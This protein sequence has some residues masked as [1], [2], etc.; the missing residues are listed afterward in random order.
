MQG[1]ARHPHLRPE[2]GA[3]AASIRRETPVGT[4]EGQIFD[5]ASLAG[6]P[7]AFPTGL[8]SKWPCAR[9][10]ELWGP[11]GRFLTSGLRLRTCSRT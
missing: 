3:L 5:A 8:E 1:P 2:L 4:S 7:F 11:R 9:S 6:L 10:L